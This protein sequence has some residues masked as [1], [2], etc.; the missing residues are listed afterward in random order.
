MRHVPEVRP[1][2]RF[3]FL[4]LLIMPAAAYAQRPG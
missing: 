3:A 2:K 1:V 4:L